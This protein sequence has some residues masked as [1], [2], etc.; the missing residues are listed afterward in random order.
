[1]QERMQDLLGDLGVF[2]RKLAS[3]HERWRPNE[4][5]RTRKRRV[6]GTIAANNR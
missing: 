5:L 4:H 1:M 3:D 2:K 6:L